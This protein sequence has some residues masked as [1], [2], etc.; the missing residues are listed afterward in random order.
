MADRQFRTDPAT[1]LVEVDGQIPSL[2]EQG[3]R[4]FDE[5]VRRWTSLA[6]EAAHDFAVPVHWILGTIFGESAGLP[7]ARSPKNAIGLMQVASDSARNGLSDDQLRDPRTNIR[8]GA[9]F[10]QRICRD[11]DE[12][13]QQASKYNAGSEL[14][15]SAHPSSSSPWGMREEAGYIDRVVA[16]ANY[17]R[18]T[19]TGECEVLAFPRKLAVVPP[20]PTAPAPAPR[21]PLGPG[22]RPPD[23][24]ETSN[25]LGAIAVGG[26]LWFLWPRRSRGPRARRRR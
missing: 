10:I 4:M 5:Q 19:F 14:N 13:P 15:G 24:R 21:P 16:A 22:L 9:R 17:A 7:N 1:G 2:T 25:P 20:G 23:G 18:D 6:C 26:L 12:L 8:A 3:A 11:G